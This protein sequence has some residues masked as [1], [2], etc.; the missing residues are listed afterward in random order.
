[1]EILWGKS[2]ENMGRSSITCGWMGNHRT[3]DGFSGNPWLLT[4]GYPKK[5]V[6]LP[7]FVAGTDGNFDGWKIKQHRGVE[8]AFHIFP[9]FC[10]VCEILVLTKLQLTEVPFLWLTP[11]V[12]NQN[13]FCLNP[14]LLKSQWCRWFSD[15]GAFRASV[16]NFSMRCS[17]TSFAFKD[18]WNQW[19]SVIKSSLFAGLSSIFV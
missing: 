17:R 2:W 8:G 12:V 4:S 11:N 15:Q 1:M 19:C 3:N 14:L 5:V 16:C 18:W 13:F 9:C 7:F 10:C 6:G